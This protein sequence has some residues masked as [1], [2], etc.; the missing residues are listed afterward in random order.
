MKKYTVAQVSEMLSVDCQTVRRWIRDGKL[1][2]EQKTRKEGNVIT[3]E[4]LRIFLSNNSHKKYIKNAAKTIGAIGSVAATAALGGTGLGLLGGSSV[5]AASILTGIMTGPVRSMLSQDKPKDKAQSRLYIEDSIV[6][7]K[8]S[9][10]SK[11]EKINQLN[12]TIL[13]LQNEIAEEEYL[14]NMLTSSESEDVQITKKE[15][16]HE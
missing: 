14:L 12:Q 5:L 13:K 8:K 16:E 6:E 4:S 3:E 9:I 2:A 1:K 11:K 15:N 7:L 10:L